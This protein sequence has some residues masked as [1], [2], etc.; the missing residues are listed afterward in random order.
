MGGDERQIYMARAM[1][2]QG[3][4]IYVWGLGACASRVSPALAVDS[5]EEALANA[6]IILLPLPASTDSVHVNC[7]MELQAALRLTT[8]VEVGHAGMILGGKLP[9]ALCA[10]GAE[11]GIRMIDYYDDELLQIRNAVPTAEGALAIAMRELPVVL[12]GIYA[13]VIGY[14]RIGTVLADTVGNMLG[15]IPIV[16][17]VW[18]FM[19][20]GFE[21]D[22]F[23]FSTMNDV[24]GAAAASFQL[25]SDAASGKRGIVRC[26]GS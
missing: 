23:L 20:D 1:A 22:N 14:G 2:R 7:P 26:T 4:K 15:G 24:L 17:D 16:R 6:D 25:V 13:A 9:P 12:D 8:L 5:Y 3:W 18:G 19:Q 11:R 10:R 21:I